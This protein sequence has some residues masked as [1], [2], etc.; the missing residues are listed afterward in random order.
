MLVELKGKVKC[1]DLAQQMKRF[2]YQRDIHF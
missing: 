2:S 1:D